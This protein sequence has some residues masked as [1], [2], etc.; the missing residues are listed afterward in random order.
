MDTFGSRLRTARNKLG[1]TQPGLA[2]KCGW[3]SQSRISMYERDVRQPSHRDLTLLAKILG[4]SVEWLLTGKEPKATPAEHIDVRQL[5]VI[6]YIQAGNPR[7][8]V[9]A[10]EAGDGFDT[11]GVDPSLAKKLGHHAFALLVDGESMLPDF[12][13]GDIV[14]ID[15][16]APVRPGDIV[17]AKLHKDQAATI[18][19]Y[20]SRGEDEE[21]TPV[22]ELVPLN[23][24]YPTITVDAGNPGHLIGPVIEH[25]RKLR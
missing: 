1:L 13:P 7:E 10:Y 15:P 12:R 6:N 11:I 19:K 9:D 23:N 22:F 20:R 21:G 17:V 14:V 8:I 25:R 3:E 4:V 2:L 24:D 16:D 5:P 18:K